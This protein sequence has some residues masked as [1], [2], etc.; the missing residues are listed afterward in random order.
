LGAGGPQEAEEPL[1]GLG[2][3]GVGDMGGVVLGTVVGVAVPDVPSREP[4]RQGAERESVK[5]NGQRGPIR[6][7][8]SVVDPVNGSCRFLRGVEAHEP[9][10]PKLQE[11]SKVR[12]RRLGQHPW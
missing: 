3:G 2:Q 5:A 1:A 4:G 12:G 8:M 7:A 11:G 6:H 10:R 9:G